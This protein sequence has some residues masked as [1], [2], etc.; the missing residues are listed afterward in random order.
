[1][2]SELRRSPLRL[3]TGA[4]VIAAVAIEIQ[5]IG[6]ALQGQARQRERILDKLEGDVHSV[7]EQVAI[8]LETPGAWADAA[9]LALRSTSALEAELFD[10]SG[11]CL[12]ARPDRAPVAHWPRPAEISGLAGTRRLLV[13]PLG[14][15][16]PRMLLYAALPGQERP[17]VLRLAFPA[18]ELLEDMQARR[19]YLL[20]HALTLLVLL[21]AGVLAVLPARALMESAPPRVLDA[22]HAA[23]ERLRDQGRAEVQRF[24]SERQRME[25][26]KHDRDAMVRAGE[27]TAGM[28]H[29]VRNGLNTILGYARLAERAPD[30]A[31]ATEAAA[32]IRDECEHLVTLVRRFMD[33]IQRDTL[34]LGSF[35]LPRML[36]RV[37]ARESSGP[38]SAGVMLREGPDTS[39]VGDEDLLERAF[40][41]LVRNARQ[42][43]GPRGHVWIEWRVEGERAAV[44]VSDD[45]PGMPAELRAALRPFFTTKAGGLGLG[46]ATALKIVRLHGGELVLGERPPHGLT[47]T[48]R[49]PLTATTQSLP[50]VT[51][52]AS[53]APSEV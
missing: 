31:T 14:T 45:G 21:L 22:Y 4:A 12:A 37:A 8:R 11:R 49:L 51:S 3:L 40:E 2:L 7:P 25:E 53:P 28:V 43:A 10:A 33:F 38:A 41:N 47:A 19:Q 24:R 39:L 15:D 18:W 52:E 46:L 29:E 44:V 1:L 13:G 34:N 48:V 36:A 35:S 50:A 9:D 23:L 26:D 42:A 17:V 20:G 27:L 30:S 16:E 5:S 32:H 6:H